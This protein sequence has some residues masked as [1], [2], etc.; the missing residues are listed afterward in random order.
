MPILKPFPKSF[1]ESEGT[2]WPKLWGFNTKK[3]PPLSSPTL[4][5]Q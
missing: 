3:T 5:I 4:A 2:R 1:I